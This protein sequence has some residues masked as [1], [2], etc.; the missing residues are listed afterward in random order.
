MGLGLG[1]MTEQGQEVWYE[2]E[3]WQV[4]SGGGVG[5]VVGGVG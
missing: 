2:G 5:W 4:G 1:A 3:G